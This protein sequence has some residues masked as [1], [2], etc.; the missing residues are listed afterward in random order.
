MCPPCGYGV[1]HPGEN[2]ADSLNRVNLFWQITAKEKIISGREGVEGG[3]ACICDGRISLVDN[4]LEG[5][6]A[7]KKATVD[8]IYWFRL[9]AYTVSKRLDHSQQKNGG[10]PQHPAIFI[11]EVNRLHRCPATS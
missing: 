7:P 5:F 1:K 6:Y 3:D 11:P 9:T 8:E 4:V 2:S 10:M